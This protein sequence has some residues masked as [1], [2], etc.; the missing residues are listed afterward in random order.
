MKKIHLIG[1]P[2]YKAENFDHLIAMFEDGSKIRLSYQEWL[3]AAEL[4]LERHQRE[5]KKVLKVDIDPVEFPL[6]C[7]SRKMGMNA[8]A[9]I[10][11]TNF[12]TEHRGIAGGSGVQATG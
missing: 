11:Y 5:G 9:R 8:H 2:W 1:M 12:V 7:A 6:W 10:A 4:G 3:K